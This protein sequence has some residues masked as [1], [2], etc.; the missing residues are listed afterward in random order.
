VI[1]YSRTGIG[2]I[3]RIVGEGAPGYACLGDLVR[4]TKVNRNSVL[5]EDRHGDCVEFLFNC[6]RDRLE[7]TEWKNDFPPIEQAK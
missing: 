6:G 5:V 3:L 7:A 2:D 1:D 4:V